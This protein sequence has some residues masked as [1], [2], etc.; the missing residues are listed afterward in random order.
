MEAM[1]PTVYLA[2]PEVFLPDPLREADA[3]KATCRAV[4][5]DGLFPADNALV[6]AA[7]EDPAAFAGRIRA[8]N[9][10]MI[11]RADAVI[12]NISPFRGPNADDGTAFEIGYAVALGKPVFLWSDESGSLLDR[13]GRRMELTTGTDGRRRD[14]TGMEVEEFGLAA[15][16]MLTAGTAVHADFAAAARAAADALLP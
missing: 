8:A 7:G 16:L 13:T 9:I 6:P 11:R 12:A 1:A 15:N 2:G 3:L 5:L 10:D 4:G 14:P